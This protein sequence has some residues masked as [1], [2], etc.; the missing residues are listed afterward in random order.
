M[1]VYGSQDQHTIVG[2][3]VDKW[4][5]ISRRQNRALHSV[6]GPAWMYGPHTCEAGTLVLGVLSE[7]FLLKIN[8]PDYG[9]KYFDTL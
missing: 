8:I 4:L 3:L 5:G 6:Q 1:L 7:T 9:L 2:P